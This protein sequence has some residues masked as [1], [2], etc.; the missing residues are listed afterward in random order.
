MFDMTGLEQSNKSFWCCPTSGAPQRDEDE[1]HKG[2]HLQEE[3]DKHKLQH[4]QLHK[5][6]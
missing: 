3:R 1:D 4:L 2:V 5:A 6:R